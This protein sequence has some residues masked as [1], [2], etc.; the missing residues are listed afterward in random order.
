MSK[1]GDEGE[2]PPPQLDEDSNP[3]VIEVGSKSGTS[4][5]P[6]LEDLMKKLEELKAKNKKLRAKEKKGKTYSTS[7]EDGDSSFE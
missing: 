6:T 3:I 4:N 2:L 1:S 7:N 5:T